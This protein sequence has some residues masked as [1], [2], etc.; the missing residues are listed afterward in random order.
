MKEIK[1]YRLRKCSDIDM[2]YPYF[3]VVDNENT[4]IFDITKSDEGEFRILFYEGVSSKWMPVS[5]L[6]TLIEDAK[7]KF[8]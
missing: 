5:M 2:E 7:K 8:D 3:E 6:E 1:S 4:T